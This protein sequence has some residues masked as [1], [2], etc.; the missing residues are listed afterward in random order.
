VIGAG[1]ARNEQRHHAVAEELVDEAARSSDGGARDADVLGDRRRVRGGA[2]ALSEPGGAADI[3]EQGRDLDR[4]AARMLLG[5]PEAAVAQLRVARVAPESQEGDERSA[6]AA[7]GREAHLAAR[8][9]W[10]MA[11][12]TPQAD[13]LRVD[14]EE[15][16]APLGV[17]VLLGVGGRLHRRRKCRPHAAG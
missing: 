14:A 11:E 1:K 6:D 12:Q 15:G 16:V 17:V 2:D 8:I 4:R 13:E 7:L 3:G 10:Q 5:G 9:G